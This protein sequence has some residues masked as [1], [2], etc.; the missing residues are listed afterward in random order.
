MQIHGNFISGTLP[1]EIDNLEHL[2]DHK[3]GRNPISGTLP[4]LKKPKLKLQKYNC[5]FCALSGT[6]P[7]VFSPS[8]FPALTQAYWDGNGFSGTLPASI[9]SLKTLETLS[10]NVNNFAGEFPAE[11]CHTHAGDCRI[12]ADAGRK[13]L[14]GYQAGKPRSAVLNLGLQSKT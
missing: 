7:D 13:W 1:P 9:G 2:V 3:L 8:G 10:F 4:P 11:F 5:N 14:E 6:F 12:G